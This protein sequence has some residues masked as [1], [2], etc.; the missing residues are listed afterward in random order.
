[1]A[2]TTD[3]SSAPAAVTAATGTI[4][5]GPALPLRTRVIYGFG[6]IASQFIWTITSSFLAVFYTDMVGI[7][8]GTV[9]VLILVARVFDA[10]IDPFI[11]ALAERTRSRFGRF[12]PW[13][14]YGMVPLSI[15]VVLTFTAPFDGKSI[16]AVIWAVLT[17]GLLGALYSSVN[18]PYGALSTVMSER[19]ADRVSLNSWRMIGTN[20]GGVVLGVAIL[21]IILAFSGGDG[22]HPTA[23]GYTIAAAVFAVAALPL[24]FLVFAT[25]REVVKPVRRDHVPF[26]TTFR[27]VLG[28]GQL[29]LLFVVLLLSLTS[30]FGRLSVV[31]FYYLNNV[32]NYALV[33]LLMALA[34]L[35]TVVGIL[36]FSRLGRRF[37][38]RNMLMISFAA[39]A[40]VL[41]ALFLTGW[42]DIGVVIGLTAL[43]GLSSYGIP[44]VLA[45]VS[46]AIDYAEDK[47]GIRTDGTSYALTSLA[48]KI[49]SAVGGAVGIALLGAIGYVASAHQQP[50]EVLHGINLVVN[51]GPAIAAALAIVP[52]LF[53]RISEARYAEIRERLDTKALAAIKLQQEG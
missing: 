16:G 12:R 10:V 13:I 11:G 40:V 36:V 37:G 32:G 52:L 22:S 50:A 27:L 14:L 51:I 41:T 49:A 20:I 39:Q 23:Q 15:M 38:K 4:T 30:L 26:S 8:A 25:S 1:M 42:E 24:F 7:A 3:Q 33:S 45:M 46:D 29:M 6:D 34:P 31:L 53:Y 21:P 28:N 35:S 48:T 2:T 9:A 18:V 17:Y 19:T 5:A 47:T 44:L 43:Y